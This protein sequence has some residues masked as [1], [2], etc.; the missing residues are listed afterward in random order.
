MIEDFKE[1]MNKFCKEIEE[2]II[3]QEEVF[4]EETNKSLTCIQVNTINQEKEKNKI[5]L[6]KT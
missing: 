1:E 6:C 2:N 3:K 4:K 5:K